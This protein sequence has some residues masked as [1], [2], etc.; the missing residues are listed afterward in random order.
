MLKKNTL[1]LL[2][3][4]VITSSFSQSD[5][6]LPRLEKDKIR[7]D[8][9]GNLI[10]LPVEL[11]GVKLS[12]V[13]DTGVSK[14]ILFNLTNIDSL[15]IRNA[16]TILIRGLGGGD[17]VEAIRSKRNFL[18]V[19]NAININ[20][21]VYV[22]FDKD[23]NFTPRLGIPIHGIIG[24]SLFKNFIVEINYASKYLKLYK[25]ATYKYK[26]C[27][28]CETFNLSFYNNKPYLE[29]EVLIEAEFKP[30]K[31]LID[32]G[33]SDALWLFEDKFLGIKPPNKMFFNDF[34][35]K[36]L[37]GNVYGK[38]S[39][40]K[41][42]K[43]K[44]FELNNVNSAFPDSSAISYARKFTKRNGSICG[45]LL[46]R[47]NLI[48]DYK[49]A[50]LTLKKN[51]NF[52]TPFYYNRSGIIIEQRGFIVVKEEAAS[53]ETNYGS[54]KSSPSIKISSVNQYTYNTK[55]AYTIVEI[56]KDSPA[57][58]AGLLEDDIILSINGKQTHTLELQNVIAYFKSKT[59][60][61][62]KLKI[63]RNGKVMLF[64]FRLE[65]VFKQK[66]LP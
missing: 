6:S 11:N 2:L 37:S 24:F 13:L 3:I 39:K 15:Q 34:L 30:I 20:Q 16:E 54:S 4:F 44:R 25:P 42:L 29:A 57:E 53:R 63:D 9:I 52:R 38:R 47:F 12:F 31:L 8:L 22:V 5:F 27:K 18:R 26:K 40:V 58:R 32:T 36:G 28:K 65:N 55:P 66:E 56:R 51:K 61:L 1:I 62:I 17:P 64:S 33:S 7:F 10:I 50:R 43:L 45:D 23:L 60:K 46:K 35:G 14:P 48:I 21:D 41:T 19:G 59:G 49:N